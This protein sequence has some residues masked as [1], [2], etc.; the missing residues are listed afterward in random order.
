[1]EYPHTIIQKLDAILY[2]TSV[3]STKNL[4]GIQVYLKDNSGCDLTLNYVEA[5]LE[6]LQ[7][8][9]YVKRQPSMAWTITIDGEVFLSQGG[10]GAK[11]LT[12]AANAEEQRLEIARLRNLDEQSEINQTRLNDLTFWLAV[13]SIAATIVALGLL[14][15]QVWIY[16]HPEP[17]PVNV[18]LQVEKKI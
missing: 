2:I 14:V 4:G 16:Y 3:S 18:K 5:I 10:Y 9:G 6:K 8:N 1:M 13:G 17:I 11:S 12:D 15:W 7:L